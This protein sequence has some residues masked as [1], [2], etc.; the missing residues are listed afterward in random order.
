MFFL[1]L[2]IILYS[3]IANLQEVKLSYIFLIL[4]TFMFTF[5]AI[6][7]LN[8][9]EFLLYH[10]VI[11][12]VFQNLLIGLGNNITDYQNNG[13]NI[14]VLLIYKEVLAVF[15]LSLLYFRYKKYIKLLKFEKVIF[16]FF[17]F[18]ALSF[19]FSE[20]T[21]LENQFFYLRQYSIVFVSYFIGRIIFFGMRNNSKNL[22]KI[23]KFI[24]LLGVLSVFIGL[25]FYLIDRDL[26]IWNDWLNLNIVLQA[27]GLQDGLPNWYT[28][29]GNFIVPRM[30]S[31]FFDVINLSYFI[32]VALCCSLLLKRNISI[33]LIRAFLLLGLLL[34]L[35]KGALGIYLLVIIWVF[36]LYIIKLKPS[37]FIFP[38]LSLLTVFFI[39]AYNSEFRSSAIVHFNGFIQPLLNS[40]Q[41][42]LGNGLGS[43]GIYYA[44]L[45]GIPAWNLS[46]MGTESFFGSLI[47]QL[48]YPGIIFYLIFFIG[49]I[50]FLLKK[51]YNNKNNYNLIVLSGVLFSILIIS[52]FQEATLG[53][54]YT[55]IL[56]IIIGF[57]I[58]NLIEHETILK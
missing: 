3:L 40:Y 1:M 34:T 15:I 23:I 20:N 18:L 26:Y 6:F 41:Y 43:G 45:A 13:N 52:L 24:I 16:P 46:Y 47:Y 25:I 51:A 8:K 35:G 56:I 53:I 14:K 31:I 22:Y 50:H 4:T 57:T 48:G 44:M 27:K 38:L 29:L 58:S 37:T 5:F 55:G 36:F 30:F 32:L 54:N 49:C 2:H 12:I 33:I 42:P 11:S 9:P 28:P 17:L 19:L 10:L 7:Y 21:N 39:I